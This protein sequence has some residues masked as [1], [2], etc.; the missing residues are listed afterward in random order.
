M[1]KI[2][3]LFAIVATISVQ[4]GFGQNQYPAN[5]TLDLLPNYYNLKDALVAG[6]TTLAATKAAELVE[7]VSGADE[8]TVDKTVKESLIKH[9]GLIAAS[10][11]LKTQREN[12]AILSD[13]LI[14]LA[15]KVKLSDVPV[16]QMYCPMKKSN[17]LSSE[18]TVKNPYYG[19]AMLTC[20]KVTETF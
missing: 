10:K 18:K 2:F 7:A 9:A 14:S 6:N 20:G 1:N 17:W 4:T 15:K 16:Y 11:A 12:F 19:S 3:L 5:N 13:E 8:K